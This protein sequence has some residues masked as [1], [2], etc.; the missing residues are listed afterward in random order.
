MKLQDVD[1]ISAYKH[2]T[3]ACIKVFF[4]R[5][6]KN[7]GDKTYYY[8]DVE[9]LSEVE[10][11]E[12]F[13]GQFYQHHEPPASIILSHEGAQIDVI[14][15]ALEQLYK[16]KAQVLNPTARH[17]ALL[18]FALVNTQQSLSLKQKGDLKVSGNLEAIRV[19]FGIKDEVKRIEVYDNSHIAGSNPVGCMVVYGLNGFDKSQYRQFNIR[20][21]G[22][23]GGDDYAMLKEVLK[24][25]LAKLDASNHPDLLLIDGGV[26]HLSTAMNVL[27]EMDLM[28]LNIVCIS[29]GVDRD[30]GREFFHQPYKAAFQLP[31]DD[32][33]LNFLQILRDEVHDYAITCHRKLRSKELRKSSLDGIPSIG[34]KRKTALLQHFGS[35]QALTE[36]TEEELS[37][38]NGISKKMAHEIFTYLHVVFKG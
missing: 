9:E 38:V 2:N 31:F 1:V 16:A 5:G 15:E 36:A 30:A 22:G 18:E 20:Q 27:N 14:S 24:R 11:I 13:I 10:I 26:G 32:K 34:D 7:Y 6:G 12:Q 29:K 28:H 19:L 33:T 4:I 23:F 35:V 21:A 3:C 37:H 17:Q 25:R 8:Q